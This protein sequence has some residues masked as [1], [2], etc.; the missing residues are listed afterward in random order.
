MNCPLAGLKVAPEGRVLLEMETLSPSLSD[1]LTTKD[2]WVPALTV[3]DERPPKVGGV[4]AD[5]IGAS[6]TLIVSDDTAV[7]GGL[8]LS[9]V[10]RVVV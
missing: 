3:N 4:F 5:D 10:V 6:L 8:L 9:V 1:E 7:C 2:A